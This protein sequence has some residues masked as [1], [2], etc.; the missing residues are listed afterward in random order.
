MT[1][2]LLSCEAGAGCANPPAR[3]THNTQPQLMLTA[4]RMYLF[5]AAAVE[6]VPALTKT[7]PKT[8]TELVANAIMP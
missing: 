7:H 1:A 3:I 8:D 6:Y 5:L 2:R 4:R